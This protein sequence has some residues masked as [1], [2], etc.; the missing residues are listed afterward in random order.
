MRGV[1]KVP[2]DQLYYFGVTSIP[3]GESG[4]HDGGDP[5]TGKR[6]DL[7]PV[8]TRLGDGRQNTIK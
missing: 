8:V 7:T 6:T 1:C 4:E 5:K 2:N 3:S